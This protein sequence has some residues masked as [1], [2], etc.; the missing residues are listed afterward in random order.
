MTMHKKFLPMLAAIAIGPALAQADVALNVTAGI[1][2]SE[3]VP[4]LLP[5]NSTVVLIADVGGNGLGNL[6]DPTSFQGDAD[7]VIIGRTGSDD[8]LAGGSLQQPFVFIGNPA[9]PL[10]GSDLYL[11]WYKTP[12]NM[13]ATG[14]GANVPYGVYTDPVGIDGSA[15]WVFP[16]DG[17]TIALNFFTESVGGS[18]PETRA[19]TNLTTNGIP[20]PASLLTLLLAGGL[21]STRTRQKNAR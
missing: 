10:V 2:Y 8:V 15:P 20:E 4:N 6:A 21:L 5:Q 12:Y 13:S 11:V 1:L 17:A 16:A 7:N 18:N 14:P 9:A 3:N 19:V